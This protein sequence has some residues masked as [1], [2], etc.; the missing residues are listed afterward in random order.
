MPAL[1]L[2]KNDYI[3]SLR[4]SSRVTHWGRRTSRSLSTRYFA[5]CKEIAQGCVCTQGMTTCTSDCL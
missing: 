2:G 5:E 4:G 3:L 1:W